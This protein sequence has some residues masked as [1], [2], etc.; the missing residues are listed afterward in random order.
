[1]GN[2]RV[3]DSASLASLLDSWLLHLRAE[4]KSPKTVKVYGDGVRRFLAWC[5]ASGS[6]ALLDRPTVNAFITDLLDNGAEP[7]T[8]RSRHLSLKRFS[9]WLAEE[10]EI[11]RDELFGS[12]P[13]KLDVK[14]VP[15]LTEDQ[16]SK[17]LKV[18]AG[19]D[20]RAVRDTAIIRLMIE[21]GAR[22]GEVIAMTI[23]DMDLARGSAVVRR[24]KGG[25]GRRI[26]IGPQASRSIDRALGSGPPR[27]VRRREATGR[28]GGRGHRRVRPRQERDRPADPGRRGTN[29]RRAGIDRRQ[30][31]PVAR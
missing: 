18:C 21:T 27:G 5:K 12:K 23:D 16:L 2:R 26:P 28:R 20:F 10:E 14:V 9:A 17:L 30:P 31:G 4:R 13:P 1:V 8:A 29:R 19:K 3:R 15:V 11:P 6:Q 7:A 24:G 25:K 22:A